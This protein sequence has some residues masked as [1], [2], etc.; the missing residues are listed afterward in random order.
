M[1]SSEVSSGRFCAISSRVLWIPDSARPLCLCITGAREANLRRVWNPP[2]AWANF[3]MVD[4]TDLIGETTDGV[5]VSAALARLWREAEPS[6]EP[7]RCDLFQYPGWRG[8]TDPPKIR[9]I[10][11]THA[12]AVRTDCFCVLKESLP[13]AEEVGDTV[14]IFGERVPGLFTGIY[15]P[16]VVY[17]HVSERMR[18]TMEAAGM[19]VTY[20]RLQRI[21]L[22]PFPRTA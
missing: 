10:P 9:A 18:D 7:V 16:P 14:R 1:S 21:E 11:W 6:I 22:H 8:A 2:R 3:D 19:R 4:R 5:V 12:E 15:S 20:Y 17:S 13:V